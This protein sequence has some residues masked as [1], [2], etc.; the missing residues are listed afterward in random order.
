MI[1]VIAESSEYP[2]VR[3]FFELFKTPWEF[4]RSNARYE[5]ILC[6]AD[7]RVSEDLAKVMVIYGGRKLSRD[8]EA[9][10]CVKSP[11]RSEATVSYRGAHVPIYGECVKFADGRGGDPN[12][13][14][15]SLICVDA[16]AQRTVA[17]IGYDLFREVRYLLTNGQPGANAGIPALDLH[18][19]MLR[20]MIVVGGAALVEIPPV[21]E[22]YQFIACLTHDV[23]HPSLRA[24]RFDH[25][26]FGFLK[27]AVFGSVRRFWQGRLTWRGLLSNWAAVLKLPLVHFRILEDFWQQLDRYPLLERGMASTFFMIPF[28]GRP[29]RGNTGAAPSYR[30]SGYGIADISCCVH[31]L[32]AAGCEIGVHGIDAWNSSASGK[33]ELNEVRRV[34]GR[35]ELGTRMHWLYFDEDSPAMLEDAGFDYDSTFGYN[36]TVGYRAGTSQAYKPLPV[37]RLLELPLHVMDTALFYPRHLDLSPA[38]AKQRVREIVD[39]VARLGGCITVNWHDRSIMPERQWGEFYG[40]LVDELSSKGAWFATASQAV[41]WFRQ[42]RSVVFEHAQPESGAI[43]ATRSTDAG[44]KQLPALQLRVHNAGHSQDSGMAGAPRL[45]E[46]VRRSEMPEPRAVVG[47]PR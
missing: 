16:S 34:C 15:E 22:G 32:Q 41:A 5:V 36:G 37:R 46:V 12:E 2:V 45:A 23:D 3:E 29:G 1:G 24:H 27:R 10:V 6:A 42:R 26:S 17:R 25:T 33:A 30:A 13:Q 18:I 9:G 47:L 31:Q 11:S 38:E 28:K 4:Y 21:P 35:S 7:V 8:S 19:A 43:A 44:N 20:D 14:A 40:E 39:G